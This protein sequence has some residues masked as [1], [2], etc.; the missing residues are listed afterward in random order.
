MAKVVVDTNVLISATLFG[1][2][3][4]KVLNTADEKRIEGNNNSKSG[5]IE[6]PFT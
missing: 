2:N 5:S 4:Q 6:K 3:P 1:G